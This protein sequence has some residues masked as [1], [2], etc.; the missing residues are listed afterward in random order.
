MAAELRFRAMGTGVLV[1]CVGGDDPELAARARARIDDLEQ[2][3]SR[4]LPDS[5][6]SAVNASAGR[7]VPVSTVTA[8]VVAAAIDGWR[9]TGGRFDPSMLRTL[10]QAGYDRSF[11]LL[12]TDARG[13]R[14]SRSVR[15]PVSGGGTSI[16]VHVDGAAGTVTV[17]VGLGLDL[18]GIGKGR[19]ADLAVADL[20]HAGAEGAC[21]DIGGD[22]RVAGRS[23]GD[24]GW[25]VGVADPSRDND[26]AA[27]AVALADGAVATSTRCR[28]RWLV[29]GRPVHHLIDPA[30]ARPAARD[31]D[32]VTVIAA[33]AW[34]AEVI[35]KAALIAGSIDGAALVEASGTSGL[36]RR[37]DGEEVRVG[38]F[39]S[40]ELAEPVSSEPTPVGGSVGGT[41]GRRP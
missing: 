27:T 34:W 8:E 20:L 41:G 14:S 4:F 24:G 5:E 35:A 33:E 23:P 28:R 1:V 25:V 6:I 16:G 39:A 15:S 36:L 17:D 9:H 21:V 3:W 13:A 11:E 38:D 12:A 18:G 29:D 26:V 40:F 2:R 32:T 31:L 22:V 7:A 19:A 30:T 37:A 10:E